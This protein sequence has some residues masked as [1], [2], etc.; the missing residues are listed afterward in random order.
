M[1]APS[2]VPDEAS[3]H[4]VP[5]TAL[6]PRVCTLVPFICIGNCT[7]RPVITSKRKGGTYYVINNTL[8]SQTT[9]V[10]RLVQ[11]NSEILHGTPFQVLDA[12]NVDDSTC[13]V[14]DLVSTPMNVPWPNGKPSYGGI[15]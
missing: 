14:I 4:H 1:H 9:Y 3:M 13:S 7:H 10:C 2:L 5:A 12:D 15:I 8:L 6:A 11:K